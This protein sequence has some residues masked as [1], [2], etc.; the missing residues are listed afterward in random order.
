MALTWSM[1]N[2]GHWGSFRDGLIL[3][4]QR[5]CR[6]YLIVTCSTA[7]MTWLL[8][9][10]EEDEILLNDSKKHRLATEGRRRGIS[11]PIA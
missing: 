3:L 6:F 10:V 7:A 1:C 9:N 11:E 4:K 5:L 8:D 2:F